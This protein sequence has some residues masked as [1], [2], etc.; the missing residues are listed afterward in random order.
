M[1]NQFLI[2]TS[3]QSPIIAALLR[4][5]SPFENAL[6]K[7]G[8][9]TLKPVDGIIRQIQETPV[10]FQLWL[11]ALLMLVQ[12]AARATTKTDLSPA[13]QALLPE[14]S[15]VTLKLKNG[16]VIRGE[17]LAEDAQKVTV[18]QGRG[19][20]VTQN[21]YARA[22]IASMEGVDACEQFAKALEAV[23]FDPAQELS[24]ENYTK[25]IA[26]LK[27]LS[28]KCPARPEA[29]AAKEKVKFLEGELDQLRLGMKKIGG[30]WLPPVAAAIKKFDAFTEQMKKLEPQN[31]PSNPRAQQAYEQMQ[32]SRREVARALP[33]LVTTRLP[34]LIK[35]KRFDEAADEMNAFLVFW[36]SRVL[37]A[38]A[39]QPDGEKIRQVFSGMDFNYLTRLQ[40]QIMDAYRAEPL[41]KSAVKLAESEVYI[42]GGYFLMGNETAGVNDDTFPFHIVFVAPFIMDK[43]EVS[44]AEYRKFVEYVQS[45]GNSSMEHPDSPPLKDHTPD[46]W[47]HDEL[48]GDD[49]P[50]V[51]VDWFDAYA[52]A[53]WANKRLPT[54][55]EWEMAARGV[56]GRKFVWGND[57]ILQQIANFPAGRDFVAAEVNRLRPPPAAP[58]KKEGLF[59]KG[60]EAPPAQPPFTLP[61]AT[62]PVNRRLPPTAP[63]SY[64]ELTNAPS[65][66]GVFHLDGN[67]S[68]WVQDFYSV[69]YYKVG[70]LRNPSGLQT[71]TV[72][73][74]RGASYL[75]GD[76]ELPVYARTRPQNENQI[77]GSTSDGKPVVGI[78]CVRSLPVAAP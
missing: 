56:D 17:L 34:S 46:G 15:E 35:E 73:V 50:V 42:P 71:G 55:A 67:A 28:G 66:Y 63:E 13:A 2:A 27:E 24:E 43:F 47:S 12:F 3:N 22:D 21:S 68:E 18:R 61:A 33:E 70:D 59:T 5:K 51:G 45:T 14:S 31:N 20:I 1:A 48:K 7:A 49:Q 64:F 38:E 72:H 29:A 10:R 25:F 53:K 36:L 6:F 26:L 76:G 11:V 39:G 57:P 19:S 41:A 62:W 58:A 65:V 40:K 23:R 32:Q 9:L 37:R 78:R 60:D 44:N 75:S 52:F 30:Q 16:A 4:E 8:G 74:I 77:N 69:D 54:E